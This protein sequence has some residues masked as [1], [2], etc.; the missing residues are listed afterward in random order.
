MLYEQRDPVVSQELQFWKR[1]LLQ[2]SRQTI[3]LRLYKS[4]INSEDDFTRSKV[5]GALNCTQCQEQ[6]SEYFSNPN[7]L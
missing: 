2:F 4:A 3:E 1:L 6:T 7:G 5:T